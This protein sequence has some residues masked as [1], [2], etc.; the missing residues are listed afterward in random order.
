MAPTP[1]SV[2]GKQGGAGLLVTY[3]NMWGWL[4]GRVPETLTHSSTLGFI[5]LRQSLPQGDC[6]YAARADLRTTPTSVCP[7]TLGGCGPLVQPAGWPAV[8]EA[9]NTQPSPVELCS[10]RSLLHPAP[11]RG[12]GLCGFGVVGSAVLVVASIRC[13]L[14][15]RMGSVS[16]CLSV[17]GTCAMHRG[18][19]S[20]A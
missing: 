17:A 5:V 12:C 18:S 14:T 20:D 4:L 13:M 1:V 19:K 7:D 8:L 9:H 11:R 15:Y 3:P 2:D 16:V 6:Q 10:W